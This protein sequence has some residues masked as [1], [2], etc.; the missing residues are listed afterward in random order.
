MN[1]C[2]KFKNAPAKDFPVNVNDRVKKNMAEGRS[3]RLFGGNKNGGT[4]QFASAN[5]LWRASLDILDFV[6]ITNASYSGGILITDWYDDKE[7]NEAIKIT[8][9]FLSNEIR[10]DAID[11][12][13]YKKNCKA[14]ENCQTNNLNGS[15][16][17][18]LKIAIL[19]KA[20]QIKKAS[21][22]KK[23]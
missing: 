22:V 9:R 5:P 2:I 16:K 6:P 10:P 12:I 15:I 8:I 19:R 4:F 7:K 3:V 23:K 13:V 21:Q 20:S 18:E 11:V 17:E 1:S 14:F